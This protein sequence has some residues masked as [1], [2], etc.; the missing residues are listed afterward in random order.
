MCIQGKRER[1]RAR[2]C[3][4]IVWRV[5][6]KTQVSFAEYRLF[7][8]ISSLLQNIV[9]FAEYRLFC[10]ISSLLQNIV[11]FAEYRLFY[12]AFLQN[13]PIIFKEPTKTRSWRAPST[14]FVCI[15][16]CVRERE[17]ERERDREIEKEKEDEGDREKK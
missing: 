10:R 13:R 6:A 17:R 12:R 14:V 15:C 7:C 11:S 2:A 3:V 16:M 8:A 1:E 9:S 4:D 5:F